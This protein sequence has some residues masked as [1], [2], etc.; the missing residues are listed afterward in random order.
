MPAHAAGV[1]EHEVVIAD[2]AHEVLEAL[3]WHPYQQLPQHA[4]RQC[5]AQNP[6]LPLALHS[7][8]T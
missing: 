5:W 8:V 1:K 2:D 4:F 6:V 7:Q 3:R